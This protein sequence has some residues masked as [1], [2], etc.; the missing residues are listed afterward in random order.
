MYK[1]CQL[2]R[3]LQ[4]NVLDRKG[5]SSHAPLL[6]SLTLL[7]QLKAGSNH[8]QVHRPKN[9]CD[10][11]FTF[12]KA[13]SR[14]KGDQ[15]VFMGLIMKCWQLQLIDLLLVN[16]CNL[17]WSTRP[18]MEGEQGNPFCLLV[19]LEQRTCRFL[20]ILQRVIDLG[21][22]WVFRWDF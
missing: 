20:F 15:K 7:T 19:I 16:L 6:H 4:Q 17:E 13:K 18:K 21:W 9:W 8:S 1:I 14:E 10:H 3:A 11:I 2:W 12:S 5:W 22:W